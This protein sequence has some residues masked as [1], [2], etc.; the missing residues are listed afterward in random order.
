MTEDTWPPKFTIA[1]APVLELFTGKSFYSS[2]DAAIR[3][4]VLNAID[5]IG[6]RHVENSELIPNIAPRAG[7][8][9]RRTVRAVRLGRAPV[10]S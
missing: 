7:P 2:E 8:G 3:E 10:G 9:D 5:A 6:R 1:A 4:A